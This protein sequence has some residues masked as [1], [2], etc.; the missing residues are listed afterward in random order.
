MAYPVRAGKI[1]TRTLEYSAAYECNL[2]CAHCSHLSPYTNEPLPSASS[3]AAD[4]ERLA[5]VLH[6]PEFRLLGGEPLLNPELVQMAR[7]VRESKIADRVAVTTNGLLL[8][9]MDDSLW[10]H[11]DTLRI[12]LYPQ[13]S[14]TAETLS[15]TEARA[16][17]TGTILCVTRRP[18]FRAIAL[19]Q[20][21]PDD[22]TARLIFMG[23]QSAHVRQCHMLSGGLLLKCPLPLGLPGLLQR[24]GGAKYEAARDGLDLHAGGDLF[25]RLRD[26]L[27]DQTPPECCRYC[28]GDAGVLVPHEQLTRSEL[29]DPALRPVTRAQ[30][31]SRTR[32]LR[33]LAVRCSGELKH[34]LGLGWTQ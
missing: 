16:H 9:R 15:K 7:M 33:G 18:R 14:P 19:T 29:Q 34:R 23:C 12:T 21:Q 31:L 3:L 6:T 10:E 13:A 24:L 4:L 20:P 27:T 1:W 5:P 30:Y 11:I 25:T 32:L 26:F 8:H 28:L 22:L 17:A 2:R